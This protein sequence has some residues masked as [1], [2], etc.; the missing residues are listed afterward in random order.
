[1]GTI[2]NT[3]CLPSDDENEGRTSAVTHHLCKKSS[4]TLDGRAPFDFGLKDKVHKSPYLPSQSTLHL[5]NAPS[6][7]LDLLDENDPF[8]SWDAGSR[9]SRHHHSPYLSDLDRNVDFDEAVEKG[10]EQ[11][12]TI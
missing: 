5:D 3:T 1:M 11:I 8:E 4:F 12:E 7:T 2:R 10:T 6:F 9:D